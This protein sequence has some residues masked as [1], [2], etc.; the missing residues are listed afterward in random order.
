MANRRTYRGAATMRSWILAFGFSAVA[1]V[2]PA[3]AYGAQSFAY[4][5]SEGDSESRSQTVSAYTINAITGALTAVPGAPF[6]AGLYPFSVA[7][8][9][10]G[11]FAYV[12]NEGS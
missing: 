9:P 6:A 5:A 4:V 7:V 8:D 3:T 2:S 1:G 10:T 11:Q 12:A